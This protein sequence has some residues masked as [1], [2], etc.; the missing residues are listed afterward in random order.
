MLKAK[1]ILIL[2]PIHMRTLILAITLILNVSFSIAQEGQYQGH[3]WKIS[4]NGLQKPSFLYGTMHVSNKVAFHLSDSFYKAIKSVDVVSLEINPETWMES[5]TSDQYVADRMGNAFSMRGDYTQNGFYKAVFLLEAPDNEMIGQAMG[6]ELGILNSL[7][8]RTSNYS[9]D[10][11]EDTYLDLFIFQA[12]K[13]QGKEITGLEKL[14]L[15]MH[16]NEEAAKPE[17]DKEKRKQEKILRE[18]NNHA[19]QKLLKDKS[20]QELMEDAYRRGDLDLL[21]SLSRL[22]SGNQKYHDL[23]I[24][25]RN[26]KMA[27][28]MDS[29]MQKKSLF[30]G[31]GAAHLPNNYGVIHLLREMG[32]TVTAVNTDKTDFGRDAKEALENTFISH[33]FTFQ[34]SFDGSFST[35][36]P[37]PLYEFPESNNVMMAAYPDMANGA[38]YVITRM[39]SFAPLHG[40]SQQ[41]YMDKI[42]SLLYENIPGKIIEKKI[43]DRDGYPGFD[44]LNQTKKGDFQRYNIIVTP[45]EIIIF[46]VGGKKEFV[47]RPEVNAFFQNI[48][49]YN[50]N[51]GKA[52]FYKPGNNAYSASLY[53]NF[54]YEAENNAFARGFWKKNVQSFDPSDSS[55]FA[56]MNRSYSDINYMEEDSFELSQMC[57]QFCYQFDYTL[58]NWNYDSFN[59]YST[60]NA[61]ASK[62]GQKPLHLRLFLKGDQYYLLMALTNNPQKSSHFFESVQFD[63]FAYNRPFKL[64][65][66]TLLYF[67]VISPVEAVPQNNYNYYYGSDDDKDD[68]YQE[69]NHSASYYNKETDET[70]EV[71]YKRFHRY[72]HFDHIDS[73][74]S[75]R[76]IYLT[77]YGDMIEQNSNT[78][79]KDGLYYYDAEATDTNTN[80]LLKARYILNKGV[81][82]TLYTELDRFR[83]PSKFITEFYNSFQ[84]WD[85]VIGSPVLEKKA[86]KFLQDL[87]SSDSLIQEAAFK[88]FDVIAFED[89]DVP[90]LIAAISRSYKAENS[91]DIKAMLLTQFCFLKHPDILP[92]LEKKFNEVEDTLKF[93]VPILQAIA[94]QKTKKSSRLFYELIEAET[95]LSNKQSEINQMFSAYT[96]SLELT[97]EFYPDM[98]LLSSLP[99]Y[100]YKSYYYLASLKDSG[101]IKKNVYKRKLK[102]I[103]WEANN[104]VKR[105]KATEAGNEPDYYETSSRYKRYDYNY[106]LY[107]YSV[108]LLPFEK[109]NNKVKKYFERIDELQMPGLSIDIAVLKAK[110]GID[111]ADSVWLN[112]AKSDNDRIVLYDRLK[113]ADRLD[114]FPPAYSSQL[115]MAAS[116]FAAEGNFNASRDSLTFVKRIFCN[117]DS[118]TGYLYFFKTKSRYSDDWKIGYLGLLPADSSDAELLGNHVEDNMRYSKFDDLDLQIEMNLRKLQMENRKRYRVEDEPRFKELNYRRRYYY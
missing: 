47:K 76:K 17:K 15:T 109:K 112:F 71:K 16:L 115:Q 2:A 48:K 31:I 108:L 4:G 8:Y 97:K 39:L 84:P 101:L 106:S 58:E 30:A 88:S 73:L 52:R 79:E 74:W 26:K 49:F 63:T 60:F 35:M 107:N 9:A 64:Q 1:S 104:E 87:R 116:M 93:Q 40:M 51:E 33:E 118:D 45:I 56:I 99:E 70:V 50:K 36:M 25:Y 117:I 111:V 24:V 100:K 42:D 77:E 10:F 105:Q 19:I 66:D 34:K 68:S 12:G 78:F 72:A 22:S 69:E 21:D 32:Y 38:T 59:H 11:Q 75:N 13:K 37:G 90:Q 113:K 82:Y 14:G 46:K 7:L 61:I 102:Q 27:E 81:M 53:G 3:L 23:I 18:R 96:D 43:I 65:R 80:R 83:A 89:E 110:N 86:T 6:Q 85:T 91:M 57:R 20:F 5:M 55:Y 103:V 114:L 62:E 98:L 54:C 95:P 28:A 67:N 92:Y 29:I 41:Q 94:Y 44:I